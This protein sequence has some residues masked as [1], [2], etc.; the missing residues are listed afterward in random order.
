MRVSHQTDPHHWCQ[1][2]TISPTHFPCSLTSSSEFHLA[3]SS[4]S[5]FHPVCSLLFILSLPS[6]PLPLSSHFVFSWFSAWPHLWRRIITKWGHCVLTVIL[7]SATR[8]RLLV[9][10]VPGCKSGTRQCS[11]SPC[12]SLF[13]TSVHTSVH[14]GTD[15]G[16]N[17]YF[18]TVGGLGRAPSV[19]CILVHFVHAV[20]DVKEWWLRRMW[21]GFA[22]CQFN[23]FSHAKAIFVLQIDDSPVY[24]KLFPHVLKM[25]IKTYKRT[26]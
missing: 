9:F 4:L 11:C 10:F 2:W 22:E 23:K 18:S 13:L 14:A 25:K 15:L 6:S 26:S 21:H 16:V 1:W 17:T 5:H 8:S 7:R 19:H 24:C 3:L 20:L 12:R